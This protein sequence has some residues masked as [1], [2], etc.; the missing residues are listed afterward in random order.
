MSMLQSR[1]YTNKHHDTGDEHSCHEPQ[2]HDLT[3]RRLHRRISLA[4]ISQQSGEWVG[5]WVGGGLSAG[6]NGAERIH[7]ETFNREVRPVHI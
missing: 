3:M 7:T 6:P 5:G 2:H 1:M 4:C